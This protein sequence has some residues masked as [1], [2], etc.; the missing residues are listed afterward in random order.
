MNTMWDK[1]RLGGSWGKGL[2]GFE[3]SLALGGWFKAAAGG[4]LWG[5]VQK[6]PKRALEE[7]TWIY[8]H[9]PALA[10]VRQII[11]SLFLG[12]HFFTCT[13]EDPAGREMDGGGRVGGCRG[14]MLSSGGGGAGQG[15]SIP[16]TS[17]IKALKKNKERVTRIQTCWARTFANTHT[18]H[19]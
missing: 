18:Q 5:H 15:H 10:K 9:F 7:S 6:S 13:N 16:F 12:F 8:T 19:L 3:P 2:L 4:L 17:F 1:G 14:Y 11:E